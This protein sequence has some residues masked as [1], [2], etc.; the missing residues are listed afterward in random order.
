M[1]SK[2]INILLGFAVLVSAY[3]HEAAGQNKYMGSATCASSN[4]HGS[5]SPRS[6]TNV[7]QNEYTTWYR[8]GAH[9]QAWKV[10]TKKE[11]K[12][13]GRHLG[14]AAPE[15][16]PLCLKCHATF[17]PNKAQQGTRYRLSDGVGCESCHGAAEKYLKPHTSRE[18]SHKQNVSLGMIDLVSLTKRAEVCMDCH[19]GTD[20]HTVN[21]RLIGAG[22][23][24]L[25]FE[26][27]TY[28]ILQPNHWEVDED[29]A[30]RK[31]PYN[32]ARA[33]LIGQTARSSE[34]L[35]AM[36]SPVRSKFGVLPELS[37]YYCY[38]CH[39]SLKED[40]WKTRSYGGRP[41][42]LHLNISS[43][44]LT[45][46][47]V[48]A[49]DPAAA[50]VLKEMIEKLPAAHVKGADANLQRDMKALLD[51]KIMPLVRSAK[52][53]TLIKTQMM[54]N[55]ASFAAAPTFHPYEAAEQC[56]M[57]MSAIAAALDQGGKKYQ[58]GIDAVYKT[59]EDEESFNP[60]SFRK[61]ASGMKAKL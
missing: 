57:A 6:G 56:A 16:A 61:A 39:H 34:M 45:V 43:L 4:C 10:L 25:T 48:E 50:K 32:S 14:I 44:L 12:T 46:Q 41:G 36:M 15:K 9:A 21:H 58:A 27:D 54:K 35:E 26:L 31:A 38:N 18:S 7:L 59:L 29:Y 60:L 53:T 3:P 55:I 30:K 1:V 52:Y 2:S 49:I 42:E 51:D 22:H 11:S 24:R 28:G 40:Q 5:V 8:N 47:G 17:V 19:L 20:D 13:I 37:M 23:P 33:W